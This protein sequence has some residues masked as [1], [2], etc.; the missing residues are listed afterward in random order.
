MGST[1][2]R[3]R[4]LG[5]SL[6]SALSSTGG[7]PGSVTSASDV[8][9]EGSVQCSRN[10]SRRE[11][12]GPP[13][14]PWMAR[15]RLSGRTLAHKGVG[16]LA[17]IEGKSTRGSG[18]LSQPVY[19]RRVSRFRI[20]RIDQTTDRTA[21]D[22]RSATTLAV[23]GCSRGPEPQRRKPAPFRARAVEQLFRTLRRG[24]RETLSR[25]G[26]RR[27]RTRQGPAARPRPPAAS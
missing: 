15:L 11:V 4:A 23:E 17:P 24:A 20:V 25:S 9:S 1:S 18:P 12:I 8:L 2:E 5:S 13:V 3:L 19:Q 10:V 6:A 16:S 7:G 26:D 14:A 21:I 22:E 27:R